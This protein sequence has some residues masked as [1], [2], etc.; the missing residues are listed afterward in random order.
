MDKKCLTRLL[1]GVI[2]LVSIA[3]HAEELFP[4]T[5]QTSSAKLIHC[6][7]AELKAFR[8][9]HVGNA[10]L[11]LEDC[12]YINNI[13]TQSPKQ[14]RFAYEKA[15]PAKAFREASD[16]YLKINLGQQYAQWEQAF[17][18]FNRNYHDVEEGDYYD[19]VFDS[20]A[21]LQLFLNQKLLG[22][23]S[24]A[25]QGV[26]YFNVWFGKEPFSEDLKKS[27]LTTRL[28]GK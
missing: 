19:L 18:G 28:S 15:I 26:A 16:E 21:G 1:I 24:N 20:K 11:Y 23:I 2:G 14:L 25:E 3:I 6:S 10:A 12:Q 13:F 8:L 5:I 22:S 27:L 7:R 4:P 9:I 17:R